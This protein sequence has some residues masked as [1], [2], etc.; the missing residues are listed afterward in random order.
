MSPA[1]EKHQDLEIICNRLHRVILAEDAKSLLKDVSALPARTTVSIMPSWDWRQPLIALGRK[2]LDDDGNPT[3]QMPVRLSWDGGAIQID[4]STLPP[5]VAGKAIGLGHEHSIASDEFPPLRTDRLSRS[6]L[7]SRLHGIVEDG[8]LALWE[9]MVAMDSQINKTV[10]RAHASVSKEIAN[11]GHEEESVLDEIDLQGVVST[12]TLGKSTEAGER[13]KL[14]SFYRMITLMVQPAA[15]RSVEPIRFMA[16]HLRR[17]AQSE[18]RKVLDDPHVGPKVRQLNRELPDLEIGDFVSEY[19]SRYPHDH[20]SKKRAVRALTVK[21]APHARR[22][23]AIED[24]HM[25]QE[26]KR[27]LEVEE[28]VIRRAFANQARAGRAA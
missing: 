21:P 6:Q 2:Q 5:T 10:L 15:F 13:Q 3:L 22:V 7:V 17:D 26:D 28:N 18:I 20:L 27:F 12:L 11:S 9:Q 23:S 16:W 1:Y 8:N 14:P 19:N 24:Y 25:P 4:Q